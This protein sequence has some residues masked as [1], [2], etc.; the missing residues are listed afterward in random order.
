MVRCAR[1]YRCESSADVQGIEPE[2]YY[3]VLF[4]R[5]G[6]RG[7]HLFDE[8]ARPHQG[9][10]A[11]SASNRSRRSFTRIGS[12]RLDRYVE[13]RARATADDPEVFAFD[14]SQPD[15]QEHLSMR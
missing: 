4:E 14:R 12:S 5:C 15:W 13:S 7:T 1:C 8:L 6:A 3:R 11:S 9:L 2:R 10:R